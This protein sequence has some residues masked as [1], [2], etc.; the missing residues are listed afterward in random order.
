MK[1]SKI[2]PLL[3]RIA[4][5]G[6]FVVSGANKLVPFI[7]IPPMPGPGGAFLGALVATGYMLPLIGATEVVFGAL[8]LAGRFVPLALTV[9]APIVV[10]VA[11]FH[12]VLVPGLPMV[13]LLLACELYLAWVYRDAFRGLLRPTTLEAASL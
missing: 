3:A 2:L 8:L 4:L 6:L 10:N 5:G 9:L 12:V 7:T 13:V 1:I 11:L